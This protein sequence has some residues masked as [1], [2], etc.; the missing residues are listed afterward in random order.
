M[1]YTIAFDAPAEKVYQDFTSREYWQSLMDVYRVHVPQSG[2][3]SYSTGEHG[4]DVV[5]VQCLPRSEL[6]PIARAVVPVDMVITRTQHFDPFDHAESSATGSYSATVTHAPG[7]LEGQ[8]LLSET[9]TGATM[10]LST[11][12]KV[13]VPLVGG[14]LEDLILH[15]IKGLFDNEAAFTADWIREHH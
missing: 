1:D 11:V 9:D 4:T 12:C 10:R 14:K 15:H 13:N 6:P 7:H 3:T 5:F 2:V 8:Y